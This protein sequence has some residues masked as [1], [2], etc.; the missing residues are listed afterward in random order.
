MITPSAANRPEKPVQYPPRD[1]RTATDARYR[2]GV[3]FNG[4]GAYG[5]IAHRSKRSGV[6]RPPSVPDAA[7]DFPR[8]KLSQLA[9]KFTT[10]NPPV[11]YGLARE[12]ETANF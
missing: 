6:T 1:R 12:G 11:I 2:E 7:V 5:T 10:L 9:E 4:D 8:F 3:S